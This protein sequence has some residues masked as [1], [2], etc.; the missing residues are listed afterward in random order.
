MIFRDFVYT[1]QLKNFISVLSALH[2]EGHAIPKIL[3]GLS[4]H[5]HVYSLKDKKFLCFLSSLIRELIL[6]SCLKQ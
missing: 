1:L 6:L 3:E 4:N 5:K 2:T